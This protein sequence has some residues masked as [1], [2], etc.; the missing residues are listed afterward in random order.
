MVPSN[1]VAERVKV[2]RKGAVCVYT[3]H[4]PEALNA[5]SDELIAELAAAMEAADADDEVRVH[6][7]TGGPKVFAAGAD[8]KGMAKA[9]AAEL[10][11]KD[12]LARWDRIGRSPKP[13]IA[14]VN[15]FALG[16]GCELAMK[17]DI[18]IAGEDAVFGQP[19]ILIGVMPG[20]GGTVRLP[21][22]VGRTRALELLLTGR[23]LPAKEAL[24]WGLVN[25]VVPAAQ[26]L[27]E[28][29]RLAEKIAAQPAAAARSIKAAVS[30]GLD[31]PAP[32]A[33][34]RERERFYALFDT[35]DQKEGMRAFAEKRKPRFQ[36]R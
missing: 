11:S 18:L 33:H 2:E 20:A 23:R 3:L 19:E 4:R 34:E 10:S 21:R 8:I 15:G 36:G 1:P 12:P 6:V 16:G 5:L 30:E 24:A 28:A 7:L 25:A 17:A 29:L 32:R 26:A 14:A 9:T 22:L 27:P 13:L 31:L 35:E